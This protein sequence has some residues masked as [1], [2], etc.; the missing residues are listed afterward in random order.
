M[1]AIRVFTGRS[2]ILLMRASLVLATIFPRCGAAERLAAAAHTDMPELAAFGLSCWLSAGVDVD[3]SFWALSSWVL[4]G[5]PV[6]PPS[7]LRPADVLN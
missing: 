7:W 6:G 5:R 1:V 4:L 3:T 2:G